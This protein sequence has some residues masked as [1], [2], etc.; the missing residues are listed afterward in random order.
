MQTPSFFD[1]LVPFFRR[2]FVA[3]CI[4]VIA[5][6]I[7]RFAGSDWNSN[8]TVTQAPTCA[9]VVIFVPVNSHSVPMDYDGHVANV[10]A[11]KA[12]DAMSDAQRRALLQTC[13]K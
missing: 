5:V 4:V 10:A 2:A 8:Q 9:S 7:L 1:S 12:W 13:A 6:A 3:L 11:I